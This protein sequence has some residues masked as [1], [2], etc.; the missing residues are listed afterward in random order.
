MRFT[1]TFC[2]KGFLIRFSRI[3]SSVNIYSGMNL[4]GPESVNRNHVGAEDS[5]SGDPVIGLIAGSRYWDK[6][7]ACRRFLG[8]L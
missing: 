4:D 7:G 8:R 6:E 5:S 3:L 1:S 2:L